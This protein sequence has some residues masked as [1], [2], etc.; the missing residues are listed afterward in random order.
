MLIRRT[1]IIKNKFGAQLLDFSSIFYHEHS[2]NRGT[3]SEPE[4]SIE[5]SLGRNGSK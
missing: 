1:V 4:L 2:P 3:V 5:K